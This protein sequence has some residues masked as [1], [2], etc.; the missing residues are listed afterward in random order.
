V[1]NNKYV[2][3]YSAGS[4]NPTVAKIQE[5]LKERGSYTGAIDGVWGGMTT[6]A[7]N[8]CIGAEDGVA[9]DHT[10][11]YM[12]IE[13]PENEDLFTRCLRLTVFFETTQMLENAFGRISGNFDGAVISYGILQFNLASG[14]LWQILS[15]VLQNDQGA[16][17]FLWEDGYSELVA[18]IIAKDK[19]YFANKVTN[20]KVLNL[21]APA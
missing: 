7:F 9:N 17:S 5:Y 14:S 12:R 18:A 6:R 19:D 11:E 15:S 4:A 3:S 16:L 2:L 21:S 8:V 13:K 1:D 10:L 20:N